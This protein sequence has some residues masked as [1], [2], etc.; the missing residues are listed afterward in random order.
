MRVS[1]TFTDPAH[2]DAVLCL[3]IVID[4]SGVFPPPLLAHFP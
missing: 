2:F 1:R 3:S 4:Y